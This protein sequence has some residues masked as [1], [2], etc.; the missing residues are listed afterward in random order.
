[1]RLLE[2]IS[3]P[4]IGSVVSRKMTANLAVEKDGLQAA[5]AG[6]LRASRS[7]RLSPPR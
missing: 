2:R 5:L 3:F 1:M 6:F 4:S 7:G